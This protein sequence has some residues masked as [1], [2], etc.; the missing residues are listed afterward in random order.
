LEELKQVATGEWHAGRS[1]EVQSQVLGRLS[2]AATLRED[3]CPSAPVEVVRGRRPG[4]VYEYS[5]GC[6]L[7]PSGAIWLA[8]SQDPGCVP[9]WGDAA[10]LLT[11]GCDL[12]SPG[13]IAARGLGVPAVA[14]ASRTIA[15]GS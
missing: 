10:A 13:L 7:P 14:G 11:T 6:A 2:A 3:E 15:A 5:L 8:E 12:W 4:P 9:L 1:D